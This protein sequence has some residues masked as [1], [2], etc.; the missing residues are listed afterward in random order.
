MPRFDPMELTLKSKSIS[1][2]NLSF[3]EG[4]HGIISAYFDQINSW[5]KEG[6]LTV[7]EPTVFDITKIREAHE[8]IQSGTSR[9]KIV[10]KV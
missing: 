4:E 8:L 9:G 7:P 2:F 1:G 3:F 10:I 5:L 6:I